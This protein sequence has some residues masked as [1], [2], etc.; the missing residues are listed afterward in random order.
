MAEWINTK[1]RGVRYREHSSR[2]HGTRKDRYYAIRYVVD[3]KRIEEGLGWESEWKKAHPQGTISLEQHSVSL[4][5]QLMQNKKAGTGAVTLKE[6]RAAA[7]AQRE[8]EV[9]ERNA[10]ARAMMTLA[11]YW[12]QTYFPVA[13]R[14]KEFSS[15]VK[16]QQHFTRWLSPIMGNMP[17]KE[18]R[19]DQFDELVKTL[20]SSGLSPRSKEYI[21][22]TLRRIL[23][24]AYDRRRVDDS[25]P[26]G[27]RIGIAGPGNNRRL[28]VI[29]H[30]EE[31]AIIEELEVID[32]HAWR[33]TRFA[34]LT[35]CRASEAFNLVWA[36]VDFSQRSIIFAETKNRDTR[37]IP[38]TQ[39]L[40][41]LL[42]S[43]PQGP[44]HER[45]FPKADGTPYTAAPSAFRTIVEKLGFNEGRSKRDRIVFHSIRHTVA[46]RLSARLGPRDLMDVMGWRTVQMAMRYV[47]S[48]EDQ[49]ARALSMLGTPVEQGTVIP[50]RAQ[51]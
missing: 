28:R 21:T 8:V 12:H 1:Q 20:T 37:T 5:A 22:G 46:T 42:S 23:K 44:S 9:A 6:R 11:E 2:N 34:F 13:Q 30:Q 7:S 47:H 50:F 14:S 32:P 27:K 38:L 33:I 49:K 48:N 4:R 25:P 36:N 24:H 31:A 3:G 35:G 17:L 29:S 10:K 41:D 51:K 45:I 16:E 40:A 19:L 43:M 18:I 15:W 39:P 26:S